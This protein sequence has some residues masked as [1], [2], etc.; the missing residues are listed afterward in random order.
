[1]RHNAQKIIEPLTGSRKKHYQFT[2][3][4][5]CTRIRVLRIYLF[6]QPPEDRP[7]VHR[8]RLRRI[9]G[10]TTSRPDSPDHAARGHGPCVAAVRGYLAGWIDTSG[11]HRETV[12]PR[13]AGVVGKS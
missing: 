10:S 2:A 9:W 1:M 13:T 8:L 7:A 3:V 4:D 12:V 5:D 6:P 11:Q